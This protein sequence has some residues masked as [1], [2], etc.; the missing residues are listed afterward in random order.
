MKLLAGVRAGASFSP[1]GKYRYA[2]TRTWDF[3]GPGALWLM[4]NPSKATAEL[5]DPTVRR[6]QAFSREWGYGSATV[7]NIFALR[8]TDP[9]ELY[10]HS[11]PVGPENDRTIFSLAGDADLVV[12][13]WG[14]HGRLQGRGAQVADLLCDVELWSLGVTG[15]GQPRH[16]LYVAGATGLERW[17]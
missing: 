14:N 4:L 17:K 15:A 10:G 3:L 1:C 9:K 5:D 6:V 8:A 13:A 7:A 2:L 11:D 12:V 16:P